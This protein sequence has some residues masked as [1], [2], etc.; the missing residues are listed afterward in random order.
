MNRPPP[1][2]YV[3]GNPLSV[4]VVLGGSGFATYQWWIGQASGWLPL[5]ALLV[6]GAVMNA[7]ERLTAYQN[8]KRAWDAMG[9][10]SR[11]GRRVNMR[12]LIVIPVWVVLT[13]VVAGFD[14]HQ[15]EGKLVT[16]SFAVASLGMVINEF[17]RHRRRQPAPRSRPRK[18]APVTI[19][20]PVPRASPG[21]KQLYKGL[22]DY[23]ARMS[24]LGGG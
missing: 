15:L 20:L 5:G 22:P 6:I 23:C 2:T 16:A 19:S 13:V 11:P 1:I 10:R 18:D 21:G 17:Q 7:S 3:I 14:R 9:G 8:W 12:L 4:L 24:Q